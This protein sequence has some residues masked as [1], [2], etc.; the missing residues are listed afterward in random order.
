MTGHGT[1]GYMRG[2]RCARCRI[3]AVERVRRWREANGPETVT[4]DMHGKPGTYSN[5]GCRCDLCRTAM[6]DYQ[7]LRREARRRGEGRRK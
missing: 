4:D 7:T 3:A 6:R 1:A 2:C 5:R